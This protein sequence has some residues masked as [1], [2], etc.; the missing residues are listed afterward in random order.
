MLLYFVKAK[1]R[2]ILH[3]RAESDGW[4]GKEHFEIHFCDANTVVAILSR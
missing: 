4:Q 3:N 2:N 1:F